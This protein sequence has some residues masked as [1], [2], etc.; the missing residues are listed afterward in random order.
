MLTDLRSHPLYPGFVKRYR[1]D[2]TRFQIE[3]CGFRPTWQ[4]IEINKEAQKPDCRVTLTSGHGT[5]KSRE[6]AILCLHFLLTFPQSNTLLTA[7][8]I[9]QVHAAVWK[10]IADMRENIK[11]NFPWLY[12]YIT[13]K[14]KL[15]YIEGF[16]DGWYALPKTAA[17]AK[18]EGISGMHRKYYLII[19][20]EASGVE[21]TIIDHIRGGL[22]GGEENSDNRMIMASQP[23]RRVG[24]FAE[25]IST[26][27]D[28]LWK[29]IR[30]NAEESPLVTETKI[31]EWLLEYGGRHSPIYQIKVLG[32]LPDVL[33]GMA[34]PR[35][36]LEE[37]VHTKVEHKSQWG[38]VL[39]VDVA[40]GVFRDSSCWALSKIS[41]YGA[42][43][44]VE[45]VE[46][47]ETLE[48]DEMKFARLVHNK[49][50]RY[51]NIT[52]AVDGVGP[53]RTVILH[54]REKGVNCEEIIWGNP[55]HSQRDRKNFK[56]LRA[57]STFQVRQSLIESRFCMTHNRKATDQGAMLPYKINEQGQYQMM[58]KDKM[59][60]EGIKS[61]DMFDV[62]C[63]TQL[64]GYIPSDTD[65]ESVKCTAQGE[66][67]GII[68]RAK[69]EL[70]N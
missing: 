49:A 37:C 18:P 23:T 19:V 53:G 27:K 8:N 2:I 65:W 6:F 16:K 56:N 68:E 45:I 21:D 47:F 7:N 52:V 24:R 58:P 20:D 50:L 32:I 12:P 51:D 66:I 9:G 35:H 67:Q 1:Y 46:F 36:W 64:C 25:A 59:R 31:R 57:W 41:G 28:I 63:F 3:V 60:A 42:D 62:V 10:E 13:Q 55:P 69:R 70:M 11:A 17:K 33:S 38:W 30:L 29:V 14:R 26:F 39:T 15:L 34:I 54:L 40:E 61:P 4:Q 44:V 48:M 43:R 22:T 5:G